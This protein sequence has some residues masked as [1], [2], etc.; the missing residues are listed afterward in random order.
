VAGNLWEPDAPATDI[1]VN[2][3]LAACLWSGTS[4]V[5]QTLVAG[6]QT[7]RVIGVVKNAYL[8]TLDRVGPMFFASG[9]AMNLLVSNDPATLAAVKAMV[10]GVEP[11]ATV[12][13]TPMTNFTR[14]QL[15]GTKSG[16]T[17]AAAL[18]VLALILGAI[19]TFGAFSYMVIERTREIGVR[20][21]L[22][23]RRVDVLRLVA[24]RTSRA[25]GAGLAAG[26]VISLLLGP[27]LSSYL[28]RLSPRDPI[29]YAGVLAVLVTTAA[30]ATALPAWRAMRVD[31]AV[32]LRHE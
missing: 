8:V 22:G 14:A 17:V 9:P 26:G 27:F 25:V 32:T 29:A 23:A 30:L 2:E 28:H 4:A 24:G 3:T 6:K 7:L 12:T 11:Q 31:P 13:Y 10:K 20:M 16:A 19:G 18:G 1:V 15:Q 5:G 21:A